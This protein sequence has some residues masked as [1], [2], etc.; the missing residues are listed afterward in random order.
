MRLKIVYDLE[1][2][3]RN[4]DINYVNRKFFNYGRD[5]FDRAPDMWP[6]VKESIEKETDEDKKFEIIRKYLTDNFLDKDIVKCNIEAI[7]K[8]WGNIEAPYF[9]KLC[10][11]MSAEKLFSEATVYITTLKICPYNFRD[12][13]FYTSLFYNLPNQIKAIMHESMHIVFRQ[14]YEE[15]LSS[16]GV[17]EQGILEIT[18]S[19][20]ELL[21]L[22][23]KEFLSSPEYNKKP[24]TKDLQEK[25]V[26]L[27]KEHKTFAYILDELI[28]MRLNVVEGERAV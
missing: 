19:L 27:C 7:N 21:N 5:D 10:K 20:T 26:R 13:Y 25:V 3:I 28:K 11:Y 9:D 14:N 2:D 4:Y 18:E 16:K 22:E 6:S 8:C 24:T 1:R 12:N 23:F 17:N 15:Y